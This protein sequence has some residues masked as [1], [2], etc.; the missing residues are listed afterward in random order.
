M[1]TPIKLYGVELETVDSYSYLVLL[2]KF[3][4][5]FCAGRK[6]IIDQENKAMYVLKHKLQ[7]IAISID[8]QLKLVLIAPILNYY[9]EGWGI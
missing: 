3:N 2:F 1:R 7:N 9:C 6:K 4:G 8:I 5:S